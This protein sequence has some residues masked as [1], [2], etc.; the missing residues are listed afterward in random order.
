MRN[1]RRSNRSIQSIRSGIRQSRRAGRSTRELSDNSKHAQ[2]GEQE[3]QA[4]STSQGSAEASLVPYNPRL[5]SRARTRLQLGDWE[6]LADLDAHELEHNPAS[7]E[8]RLLAAAGHLQR[9]GA[10]SR[11]RARALLDSAIEAG[12]DRES[13]ARILIGGASNTL[14]RIAALSN[15]ADDTVMH[16]FR[17]AIGIAM[18]DADTDLLLQPTATRQLVQL[19]HASASDALMNMAQRTALNL[20]AAEPAKFAERTITET[21][22]AEAE[23]EEPSKASEA[24]SIP[25]ELTIDGQNHRTQL[26]PNHPEAFKLEGDELAYELPGN[27]PGYLVTN[28][29]GDFEK[30]SS[31][32]RIQ[33]K[34]NTAY[35]VSGYVPTRSEQNPVFW[36]FE[37]V[38]GKRS[39]SASFPT[40]DGA[41]T[42]HIRT[43]ANPESI[44]FG[45][46]LGGKGRLDVAGVQLQLRSGADVEIAQTLQ[47]QLKQLG[48]NLEAAL[49]KNQEARSR[50][51]LSQMESFIRLQNYLGSDFVLP[52]MHGWAVSPDF[53][54][55][56]INLLEANTYDAVMEF[57]SGVSTIIVAR[58]LQK[59]KQRNPDQ[60]TLFVSFDHLEQYFNQTRQQL[61]TANVLEH[62]QL[63]LAPLVEFTATDQRVFQYY[64]C[65]PALKTAIAKLKTE[66]P[67]V[68]VL[69]DG[70]P[71]ATGELAR[72]PALPS[73]LDALPE[74]ARVD[75]LLDDYIRQDEKNIVAA[76]EKDL[77]QQQRSHGKTEYTRMEKQ[78][79]VLS[80]ESTAK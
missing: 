27:T 64:D 22:E 55:L 68:L 36:F 50:Q 40:K 7:A 10:Q 57:G 71:A 63:E 52:E 37:Y 73:V 60:H 39:A 2:S 77:N 47:S 28:Q 76:W 16:H 72:Y 74:Q 62:V 58:I 5:L 80:I 29:A 23:P 42:T 12:L 46:R 59:K 15:R 54:V 53:G 11:E 79:C 43:S 1:R 17:S 4:L 75:F 69:V 48:S 24:L 67:R 8:L 9:G 38:N 18:P 65:A 70:P 20:P 25:L 49:N 13:V 44:N 32:H 31:S 34:P 21:P 66:Q 26:V 33:L 6:Q 41:F 61:E 3:R 45:I 14:G 19:A 30:P 78:A 51:N 35:E 56:L